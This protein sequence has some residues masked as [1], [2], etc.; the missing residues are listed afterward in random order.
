MLRNASL[1]LLRG[2][3]R[4]AVGVR[5]RTQTVGRVLLALRD[6]EVRTV[7]FAEVA[8]VG[9]LHASLDGLDRITVSK[10]VFALQ[11]NVALE[12]VIHSSRHTPVDVPYR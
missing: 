4:V 11:I 6:V 2:K 8:V 7:G 10:Q 3:D 9:A 5:Q 12:D 1:T